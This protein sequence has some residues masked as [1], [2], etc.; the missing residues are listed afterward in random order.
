MLIFSNERTERLCMRE[1]CPLNFN[2]S[3]DLRQLVLI[4]HSKSLYNFCIPTP[5]GPKESV[6]Y[7]SNNFK[8]KYFSTKT[9]SY[10]ISNLMSEHVKGS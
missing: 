1:K 5:F 7:K 8:I 2:N 6:F 10:V 9:L 3:A 4:T